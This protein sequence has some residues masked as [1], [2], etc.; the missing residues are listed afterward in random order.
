MPSFSNPAS[1]LGQFATERFILM[2]DNA[3]TGGFVNGIYAKGEPV[4]REVKGYA[5]TESNDKKVQDLILIL[6]EWLLLYF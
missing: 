5:Y 4:K 2:Y 6:K 3:T 1:L